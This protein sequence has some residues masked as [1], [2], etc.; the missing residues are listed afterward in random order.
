MYDI[1]TV[2][3]RLPSPDFEAALLDKVSSLSQKV[4]EAIGRYESDGWSILDVDYLTDR[5]IIQMSQPEYL[6]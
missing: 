3:V 2:I 5:A 4:Q 1:Q 6:S